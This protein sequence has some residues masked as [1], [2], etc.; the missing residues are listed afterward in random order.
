MVAE[1]EKKD[2]IRNQMSWPPILD[3]I[4]EGSIVSKG[5]RLITF[6]GEELKDQIRSRTHRL[7]VAELN[8]KKKVLDLER[9][10]QAILD[11]IALKEAEIE[12]LQSRLQRLES[13]PLHR[14][15]SLAKGSLEVSK[16]QFQEKENEV[17]RAKTR[18]TKGLIS[19]SA[20]QDMKAELQI[21]QLRLNSAEQVLHYVSTPM[22]PL[23]INLVRL[24]LEKLKVEL[25]KYQDE[26][27]NQKEI[28][29]LERQSATRLRNREKKRLD[30]KR[31]ELEHVEL[32]APRD[33]IIQYDDSFS[34]IM[35]MGQRPR[36]KSILM[37]MPKLDTIVF[38][39]NLP[40]HLGSQFKLGDQ[41]DIHIPHLR[42]T[43]FHG[44]I[45]KISTTPK[46]L[47]DTSS[48]WSDQGKQ[49]GIKFF[50]FTITPTDDIPGLKP[51]LNARVMIRA[52]AP[53][54]GPMVPAHYLEQ[55]G[56][57]VYGSID[58]QM[59]PLEGRFIG[60]HFLL[61]D[62]ALL[63]RKLFLKGNWGDFQRPKGSELEKYSLTG[64]LKPQQA[65]AIKIPLFRSWHSD[66]EV[67]WVIQE[68]THVKEG[69]HLF[70]ILSQRS[71][72]EIKEIEDTSERTRLEME[73]SSKDH[74]LKAKN[75]S[76]D[77]QLKD[78]NLRIAETQL[79]KLQELVLDSNLISARTS[80]AIS[81]ID[82]QRAQRRLD[83][84]ISQPEW[85]SSRSLQEA[86]QNTK[87]QRLRLD[88]AKIL[89][90][91]RENPVTQ[92]QL[93]KARA[94]V[95]KA[96]FNLTRQE[97]RNQYRKGQALRSQ[98]Y[99]KHRYDYYLDRL[100]R[101]KDDLENFK[102]ISSGNGIIKYHNVW[103]HGKMVPVQAGVRV[104]SNSKVLSLIDNA[105]VFIETDVSERYT[106]KVSL[107]MTVTVDIPAMDV[108]GLEGRLSSIDEVYK[109][110]R[111]PDNDSPG[112][113]GTQ[114]SPGES[115]FRVRIEVEKEG[116]DF[117]PGAVAKITF[118]FVGK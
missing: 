107:G 26:L 17:N 83:R 72:D 49:S 10:S 16:L 80:L 13:F 6:D 24:Q 112:L 1:A 7:E 29:E 94:E 54:E 38:Q 118:P 76:F 115:A 20:L 87:E 34:Q 45:T 36:K 48:S 102:V 47:M 57:K 42:A 114:E 90:E 84:I 106:N 79:K 14:D 8:F 2:S 98:K 97:G 51:G 23:D 108:Y 9:E 105:G 62:H 89:L 111:R 110:A 58:G 11:N 88:R 33:G 70:T 101:Y 73:S 117:K 68:G 78:I 64:E 40:G 12:V 67:E 35:A 74:R 31:E 15:I 66:L 37:T 63:G 96:R 103:H 21:L 109:P 19:T 75:G 56:D 116:V 41:A 4:P 43:P 82:L 92:V 85:N 59:T 86:E 104:W 27:T 65:L 69:D 44:N 25:A 55:K 46:D 71:S 18:L 28:A 91:Q 81:K 50:P 61:D 60:P 3:L 100:Q 99:R 52:S 5:D 95:A 39:G 113:Y 32:F 53:S 22:S 30:D 93:A 77:L